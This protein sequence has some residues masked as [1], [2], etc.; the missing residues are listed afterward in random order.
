[1]T[2][3]DAIT[4]LLAAFKALAGR[5]YLIEKM[6][7]GENVAATWFRLKVLPNE[8]GS[9]SVHLDNGR[10]YDNEFKTRVEVI[11]R[12]P[13]GTVK[14]ESLRARTTELADLDRRL[15]QA[16]M[17]V[18][19]LPKEGMIVDLSDRN[20]HAE[21]TEGQVT[22]LPRQRQKPTSRRHKI[23]YP[24]RHNLEAGISVFVSE[25]SGDWLIGHENDRSM[26]FILGSF[27]DVLY[28]ISETFTVTRYSPG[29]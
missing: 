27:D 8:D 11:V 23:A 15:C 13:E 10:R 7:Q 4:A 26:V 21:Q 22:P 2:Q 29:H 16:F 17:A 28:E 24:P 5:G 14:G 3:D 19:A 12:H 1:M 6:E 9:I 18:F 25:Y 20:I